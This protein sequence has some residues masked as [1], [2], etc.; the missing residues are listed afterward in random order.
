MKLV[1]I[2]IMRHPDCVY[3]IHPVDE[4]LCD[5]PDYRK[6]VKQPMDL[7][8]ICQRVASG[9]YTEPIEE[10]EHKEEEE[11]SDDAKRENEGE[12][13]EIEETASQHSETKKEMNESNE[14]SEPIH[15][16]SKK[17]EIEE[18]S[19]SSESSD[20]SDSFI[21]SDKTS[22]N[23][24]YVDE[25]EP[26]KKPQRPPTGD[27]TSR[28]RGIY[29]V[30]EDLNLIYTNCRLYNGSDSSLYRYAI[31]MMDLTG[32][33]LRDWI[34]PLD[35]SIA[36]LLPQRLTE[37]AESD[38]ET[39][40]KRHRKRASHRSILSKFPEV[41]TILATLVTSSITSLPIQSQVTLLKALFTAVN[42]LG[43]VHEEREQRE[44]VL[45]NTKR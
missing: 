15:N 9:W 43:S 2:Q 31:K 25:P 34:L 18:S 32:T 38:D 10:S 1:L 17:M 12:K 5:V 24:D 41:K 44:A 14:P 42:Q 11:A 19:E 26:K 23:S 36:E 21:E 8:T 4:I 13:M 35:P 7:E 22:G 3:F 6:I 40:R 20:N 39:P 28:G 29:G 27:G 33:L 30:V 45:A 16:D 37:K